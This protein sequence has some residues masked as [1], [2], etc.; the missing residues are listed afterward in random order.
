MHSH[1]ECLGVVNSPVRVSELNGGTGGSVDGPLSHKDQ[2]KY[3]STK[4]DQH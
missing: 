3:N 1:E 4:L 2:S